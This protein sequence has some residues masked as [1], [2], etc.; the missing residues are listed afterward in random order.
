[1][2]NHLN[3]LLVQQQTVKSFWTPSLHAAEGN[4][5]ATRTV[6]LLAPPSLEHMYTRRQVAAEK[7]IVEAIPALAIVAS[8]PYLLPTN[9]A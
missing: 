9:L 2:T 4:M 7:G 5:G 6:N 3:S 1:M 8:F